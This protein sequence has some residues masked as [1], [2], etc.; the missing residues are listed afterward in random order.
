MKINHLI[1][2]R[3]MKLEFN[4]RMKELDIRRQ[5]LR[6][7]IKTLKGAVT[8]RQIAERF[9]MEP[10]RLSQL[11]GPN[12]IRPVQEETARGIESQLKAPR[13]WLDV[14]HGEEELVNAWNGV[15][16]PAGSEPPVTKLA[17]PDTSLRIPLLD[18]RDAAAFFEGSLTP[19]QWLAMPGPSQ[20]GTYALFVDGDSMAPRFPTGTILIVE[21]NRPAVAGNFVV[22][23]FGNDCTFKQLVKDGADWYLKPLNERYP[24][25]PLPSLTSICGVVVGTQQELV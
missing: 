5:N 6:L 23:R 14:V 25:K 9:N 10:S 4:G 22:A 7:L 2:Y 8:Q 16:A 24:V 19:Q 3:L 11:A 12:P 20:T 18:W 21:P 17:T 13:H 15:F 1:V